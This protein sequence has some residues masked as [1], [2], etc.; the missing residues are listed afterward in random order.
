MGSD[1]TGMCWRCAECIVRRPLRHPVFSIHTIESHSH[2]RTCEL[3]AGSL[4]QMSRLS[5][6]AAA[7]LKQRPSCCQIAPE[8][9]SY[10]RRQLGLERGLTACLIC[11]FRTAACACAP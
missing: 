6:V 3:F 9:G 4:H 7:V 2:S 11:E 10:K 1:R 8:C 5:S